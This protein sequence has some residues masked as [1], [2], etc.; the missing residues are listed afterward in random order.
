MTTATETTAL[1]KLCVN[2]IRVLSMDARAEGQLG[3]SR[4]ADGARPGRLRALHAR[5]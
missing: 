1:D 3:P 5:S 4:H 2:A